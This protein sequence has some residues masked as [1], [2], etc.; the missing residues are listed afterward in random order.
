[1]SPP[2]CGSRMSLVWRAPDGRA[3]LGIL[4]RRAA[5][6]RPHRRS[7]AVVGTPQ[8][9]SRIGLSYGGHDHCR[10]AVVVDTEEG[11]PPDA[12]VLVNPRGFNTIIVAILKYSSLFSRGP[13]DAHR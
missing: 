13:I 6:D 11:I 7:D 8:R 9:P 5:R 3:E 4:T 10:A 12:A 1:M 2:A